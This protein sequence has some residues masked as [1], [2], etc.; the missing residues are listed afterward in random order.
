[1]AADPDARS[2][3]QVK[4]QQFADAINT[5]LGI[6]FTAVAQPA[7]LAEP[8]GPFA[9]FAP[10]PTMEP[11]VPGQ[12][13]DVKLRLT[14]RG[15]VEVDAAGPRR[16]RG[17]ATAARVAAAPLKRDQTPTHTAHGRRVPIA[18]AG[19]RRGRISA[20]VDRREPLHDDDPA[21][22]P[23]AAAPP[24]FV[25]TSRATSSRGVPVDVARAGHAAARRSCRTAT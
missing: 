17:G 18:D 22:L 21:S 19:V 10:P 23:P 2:M 3:L 6:D 7:A 9:A 12:T 16:R 11:V 24:A 8:S 4:E 13:F 5:A 15:S 1:M 14:N 20:A 25:A